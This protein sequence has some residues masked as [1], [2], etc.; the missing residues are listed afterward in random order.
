[1]ADSAMLDFIKE[2]LGYTDAQWE[3]W[4]ENPRNLKVADHIMD[5]QKYRIVAEVTSSCGCGAG[6]G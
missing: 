6:H 5:T 3:T 4:K 2:L 1:M